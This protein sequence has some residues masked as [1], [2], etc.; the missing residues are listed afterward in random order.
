MQTVIL[1]AGRG[2]RLR[3]LTYHVPK[4]M[5][6][7]AGKNLLEHNL[8]ALPDKIDEI[9]LVIGYLGEQII[10]HFGSGYRGRKITYAKQ[11]HLYGTGHALFTCRDLLH[12]RFLVLNGDDIFGREDMEKCLRHRQCILTSEVHGKFSGGRVRLTSDG[13]LDTIIEG[14]HNR[15]SS[16]VNTGLYVIHEKFF[17]Y[18]LVRHFEKKEFL[19]PQ[20]FIQMADDIPIT[21]ERA[22][23]WLQISDKAGL[24]RAENILSSRK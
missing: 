15:A 20:T 10:N 11:P 23:F 22:S 12:G 19:L 5:I 17:S 13:H 4:P 18:P 8:D 1:A 14:V 3:P 9:I 24:R 2:T 21:I 16:L 7:I 6:R